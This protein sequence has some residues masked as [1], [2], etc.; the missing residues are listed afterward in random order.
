VR[1]VNLIPPEDRRGE[2][3][4]LRTGPLAYVIVGV[5]AAALVGVTLTVMTGNKVA[6][7]KAEVT[8]L[9]TQV[10]AAQAQAEQLNSY[11]DFAALQ[12]AR[13]ETVTSLATSRF[14][15]ERVLRELAIVIP[16][17]VWLTNL[18]ATASPDSSSTSASSS[19]TA[20]TDGVLGPS[21]DI[22]GCASGHESVAK[23]L[24]A[25]RDVDG[26]TR[27]TV[28]SSDRPG[29]DTS[30]DPNA[31]AT[32]STDGGISCA[33]YDF[34]STFEVVAAFDAAP[35]TAPTSGVPSSTTDSTS[36]TLAAGQSSVAEGQAPGK[37][38]SDADADK[39]QKGTPTASAFIPGTGS[40]P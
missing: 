35:P 16:G 30:S 18:T 27:V 40:A 5:L 12:E 17:D 10:T 21:L 37:Q 28:M 32:G 33:S 13:Q 38:S 20:P 25:L 29:A 7:R 1:P 6:E 14:D 23:F 4:P 34:I 22:Q 19:S 39:T 9:E 2:K 11:A 3:A 8:D 26:V 15:W 36:A 31:S 24:A